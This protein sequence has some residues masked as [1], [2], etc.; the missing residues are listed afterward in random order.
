MNTLFLPT[1]FVAIIRM[2]R[3]VAIVVRKRMVTMITI[4]RP[5]IVIDLIPSTSP[6]TEGA[7]TSLRED[8]LNEIAINVSFLTPYLGAPCNYKLFPI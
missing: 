8:T 5:I 3:V 6:K 1:K 4:L 2:V 7:V